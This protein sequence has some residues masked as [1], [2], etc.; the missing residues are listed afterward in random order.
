MN[1]GGP[2]TLKEVLPFLESLLTDE[3]VIRTSLPSWIQRLF[4]RYIARKRALKSAKEY[5][6]IGGGSP[7]YADTEWVAT[8]L[9]K[10]MGI[11]ILAFHRYL[12]DTHDTFCE[13]LQQYDPEKILVF[14]LFPQFSYTTTG[15]IAKWFQEHLGFKWTQKMQW[16]KSYSAHTLYI[17]VM[18][19]CAQEFL[20]EQGLQESDTVLFCSAHGLPKQF[21]L[22][23]D[24]YQKECEASFKA[25]ACCFPQAHAILAYQSKFGR[26]EWLT[27]A[28]GTLCR[29]PQLFM[30]GKKQVVF[31]PVS[32][33]SDHVET[34][35]EIEGY[36]S[37]L[38]KLGVPAY[39]CPALGRREDWM[40]AAAEMLKENAFVSNDAL[41]RVK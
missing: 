14:P 41:I 34:L 29:Q 22:E 30:E 5:A 17:K 6:L 26:Q 28:T 38:Q 35:F 15:S 20:Q 27:P 9:S 7:I 11:P 36:V 31:I 8:A 12:E 37:C 4:F 19:A 25:I 40:D 23:G 21:I 13:M 3:E 18:V 32:F 10:R 39:R 1:F 24:P 2:R 33:S 16:V